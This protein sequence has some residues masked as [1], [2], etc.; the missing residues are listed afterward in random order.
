[1]SIGYMLLYCGSSRQ[2]TDHRK[3]HLGAEGDEMLDKY[4]DS[5]LRVFVCIYVM[6]ITI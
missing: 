2:V 3:E 4:Y 5:L 1:M 6:H